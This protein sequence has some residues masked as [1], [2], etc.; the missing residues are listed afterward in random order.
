MERRGKR[1]TERGCRGGRGE[2]GGGNRG[3]YSV[4]WREG[5]E[6]GRGEQ[7]AVCDRE[8]CAL[9]GVTGCVEGGKTERLCVI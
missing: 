1:G 3:E 7:R 4:V 6:R 9:D 8:G 2:R 5:I